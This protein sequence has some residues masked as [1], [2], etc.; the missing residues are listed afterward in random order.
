MTKQA[1]TEDEIYGLLQRVTEALRTVDKIVSRQDAEVSYETMQKSGFNR[2]TG[3]RRK[4]TLADAR[5]DAR[6]AAI[7]LRAAWEIIDPMK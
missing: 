3:W 5:A 2:S 6:S 7:Q 1:L 4:Y